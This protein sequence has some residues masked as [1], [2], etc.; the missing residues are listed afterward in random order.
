MPRLDGVVLVNL[1]LYVD[2]LVRQVFALL[3]VTDHAALLGGVGRPELVQNVLQLLL[4]FLFTVLTLC[5]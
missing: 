5:V 4:G 1:L 3:V 2:V